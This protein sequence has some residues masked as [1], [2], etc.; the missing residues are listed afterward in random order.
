MARP[1]LDFWFEYASTYSYLSAMRIGEL[2][3]D[4]GVDVRW[5]PFLLGPIFKAQGWE[6]SPFNLF[7]EK[8]RYMVRDMQRICARR[9]LPFRLPKPFPQNGLY[10]ARAAMLGAGE[11]W[12]PRFTRAVFMAEFGAGAD[13]SAMNVLAACLE[14]AGADATEVLGRISED[15]I[16][17]LLRAHTEEARA[18]GVFGAPTFVVGGDELFWGDDRLEQ[19]LQ[20]AT[21]PQDGEQASAGNSEQERDNRSQGKQESGRS[22]KPGVA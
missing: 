4:A 18:L 12:I 11:G 9:G 13:I 15:G 19:A 1:G 10:A 14:N 8:G 2:A 7:P 16:K 21:R 17:N 6:T 5:R 22:Q 3:D 20:W